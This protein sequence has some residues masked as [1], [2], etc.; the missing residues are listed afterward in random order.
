MSPAAGRPEAHT[1]I[2]SLP[3]QSPPIPCRLP[4]TGL[5]RPAHCIF[6]NGRECAAAAL[7]RRGFREPPPLELPAPPRSRW[8][9]A[10]A[11]GS[12]PPALPALLRKCPCRSAGCPLPE[13]P[14][15]T[16]ACA[17]QWPGYRSDRRIETCFP[18]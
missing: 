12:R 6:A 14:S 9:S 2:A 18:R 10:P 16:A 1:V 11:L 15:S 3:L 5:A 7:L 13:P 17:P 4:T 8:L